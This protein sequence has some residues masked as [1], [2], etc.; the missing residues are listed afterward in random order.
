MG[1]AFAGSV[2]VRTNLTTLLV[3]KIAVPSL[4]YLLIFVLG[5]ILRTFR[6]LVTARMQH[7]SSMTPCPS[8][9][10]K[11]KSKTDQS[12]ASGF[13]GDT[14]APPVQHAI[15]YLIKWTHTV[16]SLMVCTTLI[17]FGQKSELQ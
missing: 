3:M 17:C 11:D 13:W 1:A 2:S 6:G 16:F 5:Q 12:S 7:Y 4:F 9:V 8:G 10:R 15:F 14:L